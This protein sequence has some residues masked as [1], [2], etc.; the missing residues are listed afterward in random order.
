MA[1]AEALK[2]VFTDV[3]QSLSSWTSEEE[4]IY[5]FY[6]WFV[7]DAKAAGKLQIEDEDPADILR[8]QLNS[9]SRAAYLD[10]ATAKQIDFIVSLASARGDYNV[11]S[12]GRLTKRE[13]SRI[14]DSFKA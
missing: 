7:Q 5:S 13:A 9:A 3:R 12:S 4:S 11:L 8:G 6:R 14:I 2:A 10:G 1:K